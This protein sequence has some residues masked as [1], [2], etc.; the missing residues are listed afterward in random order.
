MFLEQDEA[1]FDC[2]P[3]PVLWNW[4]I[5]AVVPAAA[6]QDAGE[7]HDRTLDDAVFEYGIDH[8][9]GTGGKV[10]TAASKKR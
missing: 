10:K 8:V 9:G 7:A 3:G 2:F 4:I 5:S 6:P 1:V